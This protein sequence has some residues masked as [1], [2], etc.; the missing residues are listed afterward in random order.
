MKKPCYL[1]QTQGP[2][3]E[4]RGNSNIYQS[5]RRETKEARKVEANAGEWGLTVPRSLIDSQFLK[6]KSFH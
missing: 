2:R 6:Q 5:N 3:T 1:E 4:P